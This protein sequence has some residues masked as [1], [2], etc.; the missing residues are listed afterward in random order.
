M[1]N[2][3]CAPANQGR[4][5]QF[6]HP[7]AG[8]ASVLSA[9]THGGVQIEA[10]LRGQ[11]QRKP[12]YAVRRGSRPQVA[13]DAASRAERALGACGACVSSWRIT[14]DEAQEAEGPSVARCAHCVRRSGKWGEMIQQRACDWW[15]GICSGANAGRSCFILGSCPPMAQCTLMLARN[16]LAAVSSPVHEVLDVDA[17]SA[18]VKA[19]DA[20]SV[21]SALVVLPADQLP[22]LHSRHLSPP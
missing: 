6:R 10:N 19:A 14:T 8:Q 5:A 12:T 13:C 3:T 9:G 22:L 15:S 1:K 2:S 4:S 18:V 17:L 11:L 21:Q 16:K 20:Q 7:A